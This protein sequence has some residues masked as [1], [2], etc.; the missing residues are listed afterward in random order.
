MFLV[1]FIFDFCGFFANWTNKIK[2]IAFSDPEVDVM[3]Y[4]SRF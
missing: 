1:K 4:N 2:K 3:P